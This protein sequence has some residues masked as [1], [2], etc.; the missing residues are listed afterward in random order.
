MWDL[1][2]DGDAI[3]YKA[4]HAADSRGGG[5]ANSLHNTK[6]IVRS[7]I[8][9]FYPCKAKVLLSSTNANDNFRSVIYEAYKGNRRKICNN[10]ACPG[11][12][13][14]HVGVINNVE[15]GAVYRG[16]RCTACGATVKDPKPVYYAEIRKYLIK[17][18]GALVC[19]WGEADDWLGVHRSEN[20]IIAS[21][22]KDLLMIPAWHWRLQSSTGMKVTDPGVLELKETG[23]GKDLKGF[24][25][26]WFCA[27]MLLG[28]TIDNIIKPQKNFGPVKIFNYFNDLK[29]SNPQRVWQ[30]V[31]DFYRHTGHDDA[32]LLLN[33]K[34]LWIARE[35]KQQ[36][37]EDLIQFIGTGED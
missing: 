25:F 37:S 19:R 4:G 26:K 23:S 30:H 21:A 2:I 29:D 36:F 20:T 17:K 28:D 24:G 3:V 8:D 9:R 35:P 16:F 10:K 32:T 1:R 34:L 33:A 31:K 27:Q 6:L 22:D 18:F 15:T 13:L 14:I 5:L 11:G 7:L 12:E